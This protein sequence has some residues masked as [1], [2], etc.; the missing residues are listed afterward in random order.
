[1]KF[2]PRAVALIAALFCLTASAS[3]QI[4]HLPANSPFEDIERGHQLSFFGG[5]LHAGKDPLG[6]AP[7]GGPM[8]GLRYELHLGGPAS[9]MTRFARVNSARRAINP[10]ETGSARQL[11]QQNVGLNLLDLNLVLNLT[12]QKSF[13]KLVP[14][15]NLG[16]GVGICGCNVDGDPYRFGTPFAFSLGGGLRYVTGGRFEFRADLNDYLYRIKY[17]DRYFETI[18][19]PPAAGPDQ[20]R[21]F[22]KN[23]PAVSVG[24]TFL[25][26][27]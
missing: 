23:N 18:N 3:A 15:L 4:G 17:P 14:V 26:F 9:L 20:A 24:A 5:Y 16:A 19:G 22:W 11:G 12:G 8:Y 25:F 21:S 7:Q 13:R 2:P 27:R 1:V 10:D 6:V